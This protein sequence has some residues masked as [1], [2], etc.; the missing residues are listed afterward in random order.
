MLNFKQIYDTQKIKSI[1]K[2][3]NI[4]DDIKNIEYL[5]LNKIIVYLNSNKQILKI[6][7]DNSSV[8]LGKNEYTGYNLINSNY[9]KFILPKYECVLNHDDLFIAKIEYL[10]EK[11]GNY[12]DSKNYISLDFES[13]ENSIGAKLYGEKILDKFSSSIDLSNLN[14]IK[15]NIVDFLNNNGDLKLYLNS[16]HGDFV[17]W[18]TRVINNTNYS[19]DLEHFSNEEFFFMI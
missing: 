16:S 3:N 5:N 6:Y 14:E 17:H 7:I 4:D 10:G 13:L 12:F 9:Q 1:L 11:K 18:N 19:F 2:N 15:K 8:K